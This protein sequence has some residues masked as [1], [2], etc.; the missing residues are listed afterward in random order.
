MGREESHP[1]SEA[2]GSVKLSVAVFEVKAEVPDLSAR[3]K[4]SSAKRSIEST[5]GLDV[6]LGSELWGGE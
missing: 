2:R 4:Q 3:S 5:H 1:G 6:R